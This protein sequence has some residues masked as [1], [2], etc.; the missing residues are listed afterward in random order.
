MQ[1]ISDEYKQLNKKFH[2]DCEKYGVGGP[3]WSEAI[4]NIVRTYKIKTILDYGC[5]K[6]TLRPLIKDMVKTYENYD[7]CIEE[8]SVCPHDTFDLVICMDV[9]EHVELRFT[10]NILSH[11]FRCSGKFVFFNIATS[12]AS[13]T[14]PDGRNT[15]INIMP[16]REW[17]QKLERWFNFI[18]VNR[19]VSE[20][21]SA[22]NYFGTSIKYNG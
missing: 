1:L 20:N 12:L 22:I 17:L 8:F 9:M 13:K 2:H 19:I 10:D 4:S 7:P 21:Y 15:H 3:R 16:E 5:G 6:G 11:I 14:L 18:N